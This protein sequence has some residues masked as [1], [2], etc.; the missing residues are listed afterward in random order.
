[1]LVGNLFLP[2]T[3][4]MPKNQLEMDGSGKIALGWLGGIVAIIGEM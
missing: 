3:G 4:T 1:M 2:I